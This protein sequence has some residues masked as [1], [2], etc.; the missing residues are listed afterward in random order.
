MEN[1]SQASAHPQRLALPLYITPK[2]KYLIL[3]ELARGQKTS[4]Q[5]VADFFEVTT[6]QSSKLLAGSARLT[7]RKLRKLEEL[8]LSWNDILECTSHQKQDSTTH[9]GDI[10]K[11]RKNQAR[12]FYV[13][14]ERDIKT[15][16]NNPDVS[17]RII[18][19]HS[20]SLLEVICSS[21][22]TFFN[23]DEEKD[24]LF[25]SGMS[26][27]HFVQF[28]SCITI[29]FPSGKT[30]LLGNIRN[31]KVGQVANIH[32]GGGAILF[33][34]S[35]TPGLGLENRG[36]KSAVDTW[37]NIILSAHET[38][39]QKEA[40]EAADAMIKGTRPL[41][42]D[43]LSNKIALPYGIEMNIS[44]LG[45]ITRD[46]REEQGNRRV[47]SQ[48]TFHIKLLWPEEETIRSNILRR[49]KSPKLSLCVILQDINPLEFFCTRKDGKEKL[50][51]M[52]ILLWQELGNRDVELKSS[53]T[54]FVRDFKLFEDIGFQQLL[55]CA[56]R[57]D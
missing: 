14:K 48:F 13:M 6:R 23:T 50:N 25:P 57:T 22:P 9:L 15:S 32:T 7:E 26:F 1:R 40:Q 34:S 30:I 47:Y 54:R 19:G 56:A 41:V 36:L 33:S 29:V 2:G 39:G 42:I 28:G 4:P 17:K 52:D 16:I 38:G 24:K 5:Q 49:F 46:E 45:L 18:E 8:G 3:A 11:R 12:K 10:H 55:R 20:L 27:N 37:I 35:E 44:P 51:L 53:C 43:I 31:P 21:E